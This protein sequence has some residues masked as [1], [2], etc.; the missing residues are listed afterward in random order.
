MKHFYDF[1]KQTEL[2]IV[3]LANVNVFLYRNKRSCEC[4]RT[5][6]F[7]LTFQFLIHILKEI[8]SFVLHLVYFLIL[9]FLFTFSSH[10]EYVRR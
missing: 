9:M 1:M 10:M 2:F 6:F 7:S 8:S 4:L 3:L 5:R